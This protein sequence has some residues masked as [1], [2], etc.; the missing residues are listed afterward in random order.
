M[1]LT[2]PVRLRGLA[3]ADVDDA[4]R[5][6]LQEASP[7]VALG[8]ID[9]LESAYTHLGRQPGTGSP[10]YAQELNLPGLHSWPLTQYPYLVFYVEQ[11]DHVD[12]W[13]VLHSARDI[14]AWLSE[15]APA[16]P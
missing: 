3:V 13:R 4:I 12:V 11:A 5:Y 6:D 9:R 16:L 7:E 15:G 1:S 10:R 2:K 14:P 8:F